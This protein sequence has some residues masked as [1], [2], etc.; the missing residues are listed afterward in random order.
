MKKCSFKTSIEPRELKYVTINSFLIPYKLKNPFKKEGSINIVQDYDRKYFF[1]SIPSDIELEDIVSIKGIPVRLEVYDF[2]I[3]E[4]KKDPETFIYK[5]FFKTRRDGSF[6]HGNTPFYVR[7]IDDI[8]YDKVGSH[9]EAR[10]EL[11]EGIYVTNNG[12]R[13]KEED[14]FLV[15]FKRNDLILPGDIVNGHKT[16]ITD[17]YMDSENG[18]TDEF[19]HNEEALCVDIGNKTIPVWNIQV[20]EIIVKQTGQKIIFQDE[21]KIT[22]DW[23][24]FKF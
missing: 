23:R 1:I 17:Y 22:D 21:S 14:V 2:D 16:Y 11:D 3:D 9:Y 10:E 8:I 13:L 4:V 12:K 7:T 20:D 24:I 19:C 6:Y 5:V 18:D 15:A